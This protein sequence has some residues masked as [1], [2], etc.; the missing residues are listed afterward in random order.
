MLRRNV[1]PWQIL[2]SQKN[3]YAKILPTNA[4]MASEM[5][6]TDNLS[7]A[8]PNVC[9]RSPLYDLISSVDEEYTLEDGEE[10][11][12]KNRQSSH[13]GLETIREMHSR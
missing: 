5:C 8:R 11:W 12:L 4:E 3:E 9:R 10:F 13:S 1:N 2:G 7:M 6:F